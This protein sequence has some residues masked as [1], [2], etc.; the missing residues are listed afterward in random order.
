MMKRVTAFLLVLCLVL[1]G[2]G[3]EVPTAREL[4]SFMDEFEIKNY[5]QT[6]GN[7]IRIFIPKNLPV[8]YYDF[9]AYGVG[10]DGETFNM[11]ST[12]VPEPG[13]WMDLDYVANMNTIHVEVQAWLEGK[14]ISK[15]S[16]DIDLV[17]FT[18]DKN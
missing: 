11:I 5:F 8:E 9:V 7:P 4:E 2:C 15:V 16:W 6:E 10:R 18:T 3:K 14:N 17:N 1:A 12:Q 13:K